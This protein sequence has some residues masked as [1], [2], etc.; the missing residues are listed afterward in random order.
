MQVEYSGW[1][2]DH[3]PFFCLINV[4]EQRKDYAVY[5]ENGTVA[6]QT[7]EFETVTGDWNH[8]GDVYSQFGAWFHY[9]NADGTR[10]GGAFFTPVDLVQFAIDALDAGT[11]CM[12]PRPVKVEGI[13][14][15]LPHL[16]PRLDDRLVQSER[17]A[18]H[19]DAERNR[20]MDMLGIRRPDEP[21][22]R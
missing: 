7:G 17:A 5:F 1:T 20:K 6:K 13:H 18:F 8:D 2:K 22:A 11:S 4:D 21:W 15:P 12:G 10:N 16:R 19:Q 14:V 3:G 9:Y